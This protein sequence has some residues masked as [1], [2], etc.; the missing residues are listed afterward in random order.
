M[1]KSEKETMEVFEQEPVVQ[2]TLSGVV[3]DCD[4]LNIRESPKKDA[5]VVCTIPRG[6]VVTVD[7]TESARGFYKVCLVSGIEGFCMKQYISINR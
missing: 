3:I 1:G 7:K 2:K 6:T 4:R 5:A